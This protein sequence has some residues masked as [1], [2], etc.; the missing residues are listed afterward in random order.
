M[1]KNGY[2]HIAY[3][4]QNDP[5]VQAVMANVEELLSFFDSVYQGPAD[6]L[7][8]TFQGFDTEAEIAALAN[9]EAGYDPLN[10]VATNYM[11]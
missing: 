4:P 8:F 7:N 6:V 3:A 11:V 5:D 1:R 9:T 10:N 2:T